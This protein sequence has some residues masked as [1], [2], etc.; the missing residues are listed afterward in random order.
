[1]KKRL[2]SLTLV[3]CLLINLFAGM[4]VF[5][6]DKVSSGNKVSTG[7]VKVSDALRVRS[8][9]STDSDV[10]G[11]LKNGDIVT[12]HKTVTAENGDRWYQISMGNLKGYAH[13]AYITVN[14]T[15]ET[16]E[17]FEEYLTAQ[18]FP[19]DYKPALRTVHAQYPH[20]IFRP[21]HLPMTWKEA[22]TAECAVG[23][24]TIT[25]PDAWK[26]MEYGA[27]DWEKNVYIAYDSGG[28]V[29]AAPAVVAYY[30]DP[31]NW[32][33]STYIFQFED[34]SF[35]SEQTVDGIKAILPTA[36]D[37]HAADLL[38]ASKATGVSAYFL[39]TRMAQEGSHLNG[40]GTGTVK[41]YEGYYNFF[42]YGAYAANGKSAVQNGA[43]YAKNQGWN[44]P[45][46][47]LKASAE[48]IG[49]Y[50]INL[51]QNTLYYQK[52]N[53]TNSAS[54]LYAHQYMSNVAAPSSEGRI[55]R[56]A[57]TTTQLK[58]NITFNIPVFKSMPKTVAALPSKEGNNDNF[59]TDITVIGGDPTATTDADLS[60]IASETVR[61]S[62]TKAADASS[63]ADSTSGSLSVT[64]PSGTDDESATVASASSSTNNTSKAANSTDTSASNDDETT[65]AV[66]ARIGDSSP[67]KETANGTSATL[68]KP[69]DATSATKNSTSTIQS[70][71]STLQSATS[72][73]QTTTTNTQESTPPTVIS[74]PLTPSFD[75]YTM[76]YSLQVSEAVSSITVKA[77]LSNKD[78]TLEGDG[79]VKLELGE[80][81]IPL[82]VTAT[83]GAIRTYTLT[84]IREGGVIDPPKI[85]GKV[86]SIKDIVTKVE[87]D[88]SVAE[89]VKNLAVT[90]GTA[91][92]TTADGDKKASGIIGTGDILRLY[93]GKVLCASYPIIIYGDVNGDGK[94]SSL[95]LRIAQK[96]ILKI[97]ELDGYY[98]NAADSS[99]DEKLTSLDLRVTQKYIL[100]ITKTLQ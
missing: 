44:T 99:K 61:E 45:Y 52:F 31:R 59:L 15:Y 67:S 41:G 98:L 38:K 36:L 73:V 65:I 56:N 1:M 63:S 11:H 72:A 19:E 20:W 100:K 42:N 96:H 39:A 40:L 28:W 6:A 97:D 4:A 14:A 83:S 13:S 34:L 77:T 69:S 25:S 75:R 8:E 23:L 76:A 74:T 51:G 7:T 37:K 78:A 82:T 53:F 21:Q 90:D 10:V 58:N 48:R 62:T 66:Q 46:K 60:T 18:G 80:N 35:G 49:K 87:P 55:R 86:Y 94:I 29:T 16:D 30:M 88:T 5:A 64:N 81:T 71:T 22:Y 43:I 50:Y 70:S 91:V 12:I 89:F 68:K 54:G 27:Y 92:V 2:I 95:D 17:E 33:D 9:A 32:L 84:V 26:S 47:C 3:V 79:I 85:T 24:N 93:S 57:A